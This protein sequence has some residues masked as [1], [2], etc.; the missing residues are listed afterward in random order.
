[1]GVYHHYDGHIDTTEKVA[2]RISQLL[3]Q[4][5]VL[6]ERVA[7]KPLPDGRV[8]VEFGEYGK[9][10]ADFDADMEK[11]LTLA[12]RN[13]AVGRVSGRREYDDH[14]E[15]GWTVNGETIERVVPVTIYNYE[16]VD[17]VDIS[18]VPNTYSATGRYGIAISGTD[19]PADIVDIAPRAVE[20]A[21]RS[22]TDIDTSVSSDGGVYSVTATF[23]TGVV[24][25]ADVV[26]DLDMV[27]DQLGDSLERQLGHLFP[28]IRIDVTTLDRDV[29]AD[30]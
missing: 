7:T 2:V 9:V 26:A 23:S 3:E 29:T 24:D 8:R 10:R 22:L 18:E 21:C 4:H 20:V 12:A 6:P 13:G 14:D 19:L 11:V 27:A 16:T 30:A 15:F 25:R 1:M 28:G 5:L 17:P